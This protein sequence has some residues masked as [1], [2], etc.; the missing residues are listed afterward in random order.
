MTEEFVTKSILR[1]LMENGWEIVCFD[2]PQSGT[3]RVLH[4]DGEA[5]SKTLGAIVP[6][7]VAVR[8]GVCLCF[9]NKNRHSRADF[10]KVN[11]VKAGNHYDKAFVALL[12]GHAVSRM[13]FGIGMPASAYGAKAAAD[14]YLVDFIFCVA[15]DGSLAIPFPP[16]GTPSFGVTANVSAPR[17]S[18]HPL[19]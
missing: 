19:T 1:H 4:P 3:G 14:S 7:I 6:D 12:E 11:A 8:D 18:A 9:E 15:E 10:E 5:Q 13:L 2:F 16:S 17:S